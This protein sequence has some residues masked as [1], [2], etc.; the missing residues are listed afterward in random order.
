MINIIRIN[1]LYKN[2]SEEIN[3]NKNGQL[4]NI[5]NL[6]QGKDI[7]ENNEIS[8]ENNKNNSGLCNNFSFNII[9]KDLYERK[10]ECILNNYEIYIFLIK[11]IENIVECYKNND[12]H[13]NNIF[14][15]YDFKSI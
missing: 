14:N 3:G 2:N 7:K 12:I 5:Y 9:I 11:Y 13:R 8:Y 10:I 15:I 1:S 4:Y 6:I